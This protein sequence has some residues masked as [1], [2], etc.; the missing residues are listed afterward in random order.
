MNKMDERI[1]QTKQTIESKAFSIC[2][3]SLWGIIAFR[4]FI[5]QQSINEYADIFLLTII[6]SLYV[7]YSNLI[8]GVF[9][10]TE[11][12]TSKSK[13]ISF[14]LELVFYVGFVLVF[15]FITGI[16]EYSKLSVALSL[17]IIVRLSIKFLA[18]TSDKI[19]NRDIEE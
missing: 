1:K 18:R 10:I 12:N 7:V 3:L 5:L 11:E 13:F 14:I 19:A 6:V 17:V 15:R 4:Q 2:Y 9:N 8:Q 16:Q